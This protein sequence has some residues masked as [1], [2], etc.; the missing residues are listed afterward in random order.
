V[1]E[2]VRN[3]FAQIRRHP[4]R[5]FI[6]HYSSES[7]FDSDHQNMSPRIT[8]IVVRHYATGQAVSFSLHTIAEYLGV[9]K[10]EVGLKYNEIERELLKQFYDFVLERRDRYWVHW[11]MRNVVFGFEHIE[12]R[13]RVLNQKDPPIIPVENRINLN[14]VLKRRY[15]SDYVDDPRMPTLMNLNG[16]LVQGF[17]TGKEESEAFAAKD[18]IRMHTSTIAKVG[19]FSFVI[20]SALKGRLRTSGSGWGNK[21]DRLLESRKSRVIAVGATLVGGLVALVQGG[22][23]ILG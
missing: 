4:S 14:D 8:S 10:E 23:W 15:G 21:V 3:F 6:I 18:F 2:I 20:G 22:I 11:N 17:L 16:G 12:H 5:F 7:L 9:S 13:F 1:A 19:F